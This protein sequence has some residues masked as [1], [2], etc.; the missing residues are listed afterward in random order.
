MSGEIKLGDPVPWFDARTIAGA[1]INL[2]VVAGRWVALCFLNSLNNPDTSKQ[3]AEL[4]SEAGLFTD[5]HMIFYGVLT[6][7]PIEAQKLADASH[8]ALGFIADYTKDITRL[9]GAENSSRLV[10][11]DPLLRVIGN[12]PLGGTPTEVLRKFLRDLPSIDN[13]A[14]VPLTAPA[15]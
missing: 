9:Y 15:L 2:G 11:L 6:E 1:S 3:L 12:F 4:L 13:S 7:P 14:G 8:K 10:V 5:D